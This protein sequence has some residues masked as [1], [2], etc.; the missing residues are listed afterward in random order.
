MKKIIGISCLATNRAI[1]YKNKLIFN[2]KN[3]M[4]FFRNTTIKTEIFKKQNAVIMG[5]K[6]FDSIPGKGLPNRLN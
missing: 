2:L 5:R 3:D 4:K 1:G 6:T